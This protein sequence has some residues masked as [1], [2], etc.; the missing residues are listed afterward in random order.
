MS[1]YKTFIFPIL[2]QK[3]PEQVHYLAMDALKFFYK[4]PFAKGILTSLFSIEDKRLEREVFGLKFKNPIGLA[5]GFD[6]NARWVD[7]LTT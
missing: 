1:F 6:K 4:L 3:D 5:A 7:E 2:K